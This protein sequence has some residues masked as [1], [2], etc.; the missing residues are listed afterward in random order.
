MK[1]PWVENNAAAT[2]VDCRAQKAVAGADSTSL[3]PTDQIRLPV[4]EAAR[5]SPR[6]GAYPIARRY[7]S[8][9]AANAALPPPF[10][11]RPVQAP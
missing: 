9:D 7:L 10:T 2:I 8:T 5:P 6:A 11:L 3:P 4:S 1:L